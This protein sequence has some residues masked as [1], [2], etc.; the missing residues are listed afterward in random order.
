MEFKK[1]PI[2]FALCFTTQRR[3]MQHRNEA[4]MAVLN[5]IFRRIGL[6]VL[7][8]LLIF[9]TA[10]AQRTQSGQSSLRV[11]SLYNGLS[12]GAEAFYEQ[13]TLSGYWTVGAQGNHYRAG[14]STGDTLD[15]IHAL[16]EGGYLFRLAGARNRSFSFYAGGGVLAGI[17]ILDPLSSLP[18]YITLSSKR[19]SFL[20]GLYPEIVLEWFLSTRFA[21]TLQASAPVTFGSGISAIHGNIGLGMKFNL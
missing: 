17:E 10:S 20:Y 12:A 3:V 19:Y 16:A 14:L 1:I 2:Y 8:S 4:K 5:N 13:Y 21:L 6:L 18:G 11:S 9:Q 7:T 15:Y